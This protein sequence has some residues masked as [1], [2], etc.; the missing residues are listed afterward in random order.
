MTCRHTEI[1]CYK[2]SDELDAH[3]RTV[4]LLERIRM[5][6]YASRDMALMLMRRKK[7]KKGEERGRQQREAV[8]KQVDPFQQI[9]FSSK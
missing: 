1:N 4:K 9:M 3:M 8:K 2:T 5:K 6:Q 7:K